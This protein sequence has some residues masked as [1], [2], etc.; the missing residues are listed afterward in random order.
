MTCSVA[1]GGDPLCGRCI[2]I[3]ALSAPMRRARPGLSEPASWRISSRFRDGQGNIVSAAPA[4]Q[5][6][7]A[8][9]GMREES[10]L[11]VNGT[12]CA[13]RRRRAQDRERRKIPFGESCLCPPRWQSLPCCALRDTPDLWP[14]EVLRHTASPTHLMATL[15]TE[16]RSKTSIGLRRIN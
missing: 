6:V 10:R 15:S 8:E 12:P 11:G 9:A 7:P 13:A 14:P 1:K 2:G 4:A 16:S 5:S 3:A